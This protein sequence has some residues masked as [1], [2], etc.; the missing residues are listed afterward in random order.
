[1]G[2]ALERTVNV[3]WHGYFAGA[4]TIVPVERETTITVAIPIGLGDVATFEGSEQMQSVVLF[5]VAYAEIVDHERK[6]DVACKMF[7][8]AWGSGARNIAVGARE[9]REDY[10][11][12]GVQPGVNHTC[13]DGFQR[14]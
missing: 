1:M 4:C 14:T 8:K 5:G 3:A 13:H 6:Y 11:L 10:R 7:P 9:T 12:L 2:K